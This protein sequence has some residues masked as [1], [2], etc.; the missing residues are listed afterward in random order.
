MFSHPEANV[1]ET[2]DILGIVSEPQFEGLASTKFSFLLFGC[3]AASNQRQLYYGATQLD[4]MLEKLWTLI[5][6]HIAYVVIGHLTN[7]D[8]P[9]CLLGSLQN[10]LDTSILIGLTLILQHIA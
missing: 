2:A 3:P 10:A 8:F 5:V 6:N 7:G 9:S 4:L 1:I